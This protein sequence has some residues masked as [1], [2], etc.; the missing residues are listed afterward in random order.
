MIS[1]ISVYQ[2]PLCQ[3]KKRLPRPNFTPPCLSV[4]SEEPARPH[5]RHPAVSPCAGRSR[6]TSFNHQAPLL[7]LRHFVHTPPVASRSAITPMQLFACTCRRSLMAYRVSRGVQIRGRPSA[8]CSGSGPVASAARLHS[9]AI[10]RAFT[11]AGFA[12]RVT[13]GIKRVVPHVTG[14]AVNGPPRPMPWRVCGLVCAC[15]WVRCWAG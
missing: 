11:A 9:V 8:H 13:P 3:P 15:R 14:T 12:V 1:E 7:T 10:G 5:T 2:E 6:G 4:S